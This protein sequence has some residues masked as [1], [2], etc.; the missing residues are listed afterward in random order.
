GVVY[1]QLI[2]FTVGVVVGTVYVWRLVSAHIGRIQPVLQLRRLYSYALPLGLNLLTTLGLA[3]TDLFLL[4]V[5][6][7]AEMVGTYRGCMQIVLVFDLVSNACAAALAPIFT[8]LIAE[9]R[10]GSLQE[11][12]TSAVRLLTLMALP[13]LLVIIVNAADLLRALGPAFSVGAPALLLL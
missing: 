3:W 7:N 10:R 8:V 6:T 4:C 5:L 9:G 11:T 12:Y 1:G 2:G 13:L